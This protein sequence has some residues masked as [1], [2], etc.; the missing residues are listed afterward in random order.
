MNCPPLPTLDWG[1]WGSWGRGDR[2][3]NHNSHCYSRWWGVP[4]T[5]T[6]S[7]NPASRGVQ[8]DERGSCRG[9]RRD[10]HGQPS[11]QMLL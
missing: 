9:G 8:P 1:G 6:A 11:V 2:A 10:T 4:A 7:H 3:K 5:S